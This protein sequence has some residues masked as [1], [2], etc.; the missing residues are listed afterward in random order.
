MTRIE[1]MMDPVNVI[2]LIFAC[3][4]VIFSK[5]QYARSRFTWMI[6]KLSQNAMKLPCYTTLKRKVEFI[7]LKFSYAGSTIYSFKCSSRF[8]AASRSNTALTIEGP[9]S[10]DR[11]F[12]RALV[13]KPSE[14]AIL[15]VSTGPI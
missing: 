15:D 14:S 13:L 8:F 7:A 10:D 6:S 2:A 12:L 4:T 1:V 5:A 11:C 9:P 3:K